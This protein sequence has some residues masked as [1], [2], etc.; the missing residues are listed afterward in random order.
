MRV[1]WFCGSEGWIWMVRGARSPEVGVCFVNCLRGGRYLS[2]LTR[3]C[4]LLRFTGSGLYYV[5]EHDQRRCCEIAEESPRCLRH[6]A[7][8]TPTVGLE[9]TTTRLKALR[10]A[11]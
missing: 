5:F 6:S 7:K 9:A 10:S 11:D 2:K 4:E 3:Q 1:C 8:E